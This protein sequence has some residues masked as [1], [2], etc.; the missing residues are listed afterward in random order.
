[1]PTYNYK[2]L[3]TGEIIQR[4]VPFNKRDKQEG[5]ERVASFPKQI[6]TEANSETH[7]DGRAVRD[8][9]FARHLQIAKMNEIAANSRPEKAAEIKE[10][11]KKLKEDIYT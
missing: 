4:F 9:K 3:E 8:P 11:I 7:M 2:N 10:D 6:R 5:F 1:M